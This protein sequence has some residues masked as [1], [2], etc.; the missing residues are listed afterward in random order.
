ME[1]DF[2][3]TRKKTPMLTTE[4]VKQTDAFKSLTKTMQSIVRSYNNIKL[5]QNG[6]SIVGYKGFELFEKEHNYSWVNLMIIKEL[7]NE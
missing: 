2:L 5:I 3:I 6:I 1:R 4:R 7:T